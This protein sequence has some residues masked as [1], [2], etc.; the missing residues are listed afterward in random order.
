[1]D[2]KSAHCFPN[3]T[4]GFSSNSFRTHLR[5]TYHASFLRTGAQASYDSQSQPITEF[6]HGLGQKLCYK[7]CR[8]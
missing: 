7:G 1:M 4:G 2:K 6:P 3:V 8:P 5:Y